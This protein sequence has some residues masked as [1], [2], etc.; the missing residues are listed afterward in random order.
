GVHSPEFAFEKDP[1]NVAAAVKRLDVT[2]P[3]ALDS[4]YA[5]WQ[6]FNNEY[7]PADYFIDAHGRIRAHY[8]GEG[9]YREGEDTIRQLLTEA[10]YKDLPGGYVQPGAK[11]AQAAGSGDQQRAPETSPAAR[12]RTTTRSTT[13]RRRNSPPTSGRCPAAG[14]CMR[15]TPRW[16]RP[17]APSATASV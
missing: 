4:D 13:A 14:P 10:G 11:G 8:F 2:Y 17:M 5:I 16:M 15:R 7:W 1:A 9:G 12:S 3:V 6:G